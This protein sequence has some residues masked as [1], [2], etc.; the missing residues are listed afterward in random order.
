MTMTTDPVAEA[1]TKRIEDGAYGFVDV[2][3]EL[4]ARGETVVPY[5]RFTTEA[6][7]Y[8]APV[9]AGSAPQPLVLGVDVEHGVGF[10]AV[11]LRTTAGS[12]RLWLELT[13]GHVV[14]SVQQ[15]TDDYAAQ[16][17]R[18]LGVTA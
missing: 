2:E 18:V 4:D 9:Y 16:V 14:E 11:D 3:C 6:G 17:R 15:L 5:V 7:E 13:D 10:S 1:I 12:Y 8:V